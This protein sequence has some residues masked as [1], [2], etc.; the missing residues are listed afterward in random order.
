MYANAAVHFKDPFAARNSTLNRQPH[1][2]SQPQA[3]WKFPASKPEHSR[4]LTPPP[5]MNGVGHAFRHGVYQ[6]QGKRYNDY[7]SNYP[8]YGAS[9][10]QYTAYEPSAASSQTAGTRSHTISPAPQARQSRLPP[11]D[12]PSESRSQSRRTSQNA[13]APS[14]QIPKS[15][16]DSGG[17]LSELAAQVGMLTG[18][19]GS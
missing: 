14:F 13:I 4:A 11:L 9:G 15:V 17:S 5:D 12:V 16:N 8:P 7:S 19:T 3:S 18:R 1:H 2:Y 6:E 10:P